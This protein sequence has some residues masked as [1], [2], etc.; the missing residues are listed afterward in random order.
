MPTTCTRR[1]HGW[2][3]FGLA[4]CVAVLTIPA[5]A[6]GKRDASPMVK[7]KAGTFIMG[8]AA[9]LAMDGPRR[10]LEVGTFEIDKYEVSNARYRK[11]LDWVK[12]NGDEKIRHADQ[13][14]GKDHTPRYWKSFRPALLET[15]GMAKLQHFDASTFRKDDHP[16]V[17]VDWFDAYAFAKWAG[18]RLPTEAEWE[19]AARGTK[20]R[21]WPWGN[22]WDFAKCNSG[23]Y[24]W[25]GERD[26]FIYAAPVKA[27]AAG[28]SPYGCHQMAG[29]VAEWVNERYVPKKG[30]RSRV[31]AGAMIVKGGS[32][33]SYPSSVRPAARAAHERSY[34]HFTIG[35]RCANSKKKRGG[36]S[37][38]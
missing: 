35:F 14:A 18:K 9:G 8:D 1:T 17:G 13:P 7:V 27:F 34:R 22:K 20:G 32:S 2:R 30:D 23:G 12:K 25:K 21:T 31:P 26:G 4:A 37:D 15:T 36:A 33:S 38:G 19:K 24:E 6:A 28:R 5:A 3:H 10:T 16:V 29:N 11:F